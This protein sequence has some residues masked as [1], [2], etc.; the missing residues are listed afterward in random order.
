MRVGVFVYKS[1]RSVTH[2]AC[3]FCNDESAVH[4]VDPLLDLRY[5]FE[6]IKELKCMIEARRLKVDVESV[7]ANY[8]RW[9]DVYTKW[10][11]SSVES[12]AGN[13]SR[14]RELRQR[15]LN[16]SEGLLGA[17][18][19]PNDLSGSA[20]CSL[21]VVPYINK[22]DSEQNGKHIFFL[23]KAGMIK[24]EPSIS[25][26]HLIG[27][28]ASLQYFLQKLFRE[29]F[30]GNT[31]NVSPPY[32]V[33]GA[34]IDGV[35]V[36]KESFPVFASAMH[37]GSLL[38]LAGH[39]ISSLVS[40]FVKKSLML[41]TN[42]WPLR[43]LSSGASYTIPSNTS[44]M[45][46]LNNISQR[47]KTVLLSLCKTQEEEDTEYKSLSKSLQAILENK[48]S[49]EIASSIVPAHKLLNFE[50]AAIGLSTSTG[51][52][53]ARICTI[54]SYISR[55]LCISLDLKPGSVSFVRMVFVDIDL[56]RIVASMIE[57]HLISGESVSEN[58][59]SFLV[60]SLIE[61]SNS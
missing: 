32:F 33:R 30:A 47:S 21:D 58:V 2:L 45:L 25:N 12:H 29:E 51:I 42:R 27:L 56:T 52:E 41:K 31:L 54:G 36:S 53:V 26:A 20:I 3:R 15:M 28:P 43:L 18:R 34:I 60:R 10:R 11:D 8:Y 49:L 59:H 23:Q 17:L 46:N 44:S 19:L 5:R 24:V 35:N 48:L 57:K 14:D 4:V 16:E 38:Y 39:S 9:W 40:L 55:R 37:K 22:V 7:A 6:D 61:S 50:S 13:M 1:S